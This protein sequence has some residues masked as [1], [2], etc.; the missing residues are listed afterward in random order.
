[1]ISA[2]FDLLPGRSCSR[3]QNPDIIEANTDTKAH[4]ATQT[5]MYKPSSRFN[6]VY[7]PCAREDDNVNLGLAFRGCMFCTVL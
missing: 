1:M 7:L 4:A 6:F 3:T 2:N 5:R